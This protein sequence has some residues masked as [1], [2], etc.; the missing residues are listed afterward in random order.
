SFRK[1]MRHVAGQVARWQRRRQAGAGEARPVP[2]AQIAHQAAQTIAQLPTDATNGASVVIADEEAT[3]VSEGT[4]AVI[5]DLDD[6]LPL[7]RGSA[8][9]LER[10]CRFLLLNGVRAAVAGDRRGR[11]PSPS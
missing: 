7:V 11:V 3:P 9:D 8:A 1:Q 4:V 10:L 6:E 2:L 5:L